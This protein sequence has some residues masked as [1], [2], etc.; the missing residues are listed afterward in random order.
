MAIQNK[1][2]GLSISSSKIMYQALKLYQEALLRTTATPETHED[3]RDA[4]ITT[5]YLLDEVSQ[6]INYHKKNGEN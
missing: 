4:T 2:N 5:Q 6:I 1:M 3:T